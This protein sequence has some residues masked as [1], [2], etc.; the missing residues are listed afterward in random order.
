MRKLWKK[1][2]FWIDRKP[3]KVSF[4]TRLIAYGID[5]AIGGII[6]GFPAVFIY[7]LV[8][9]RSDMFSD[10]YVFPSLG[11]PEY[12]SYIAG[13]L[14]IIV[15]LIYLIYIPYKV[16]PGQTLGKRIMKIKIVKLD[17]QP[18]DVKTL[19]LRHVVGLMLLESV[20]VVVARYYRQMLTLA[21]GIYFEYYL[22]A[23]GSVITIISAILVYNTASRRAIHDYIAKTRVALV[24]EECVPEPPKKIKP[25]RHK[26]RHK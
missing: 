20:S 15:A 5:W 1:L 18:L 19:L 4:I 24:D 23:I 21:T 25:K 26:K 9:D 11:Y 3:S 14:C 6:A 10:L 7:A 22:M 12:W 13:L 16:Y 8:T 2:T 17:F